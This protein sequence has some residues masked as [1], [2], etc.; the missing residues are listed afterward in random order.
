MAGRPAKRLSEHVWESSF[1]ARDHAHLLDDSELAEHPRL[2]RLQLAY[3]ETADPGLRRQLALAFERVS[4]NTEDAPTQVELEMF[5]GQPLEEASRPTRHELDAE[6]AEVVDRPP[7]PIEL[8]HDDAL[9]AHYW[10]AHRAAELFDAGRSG[11]EI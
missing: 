5:A 8:A 4:R 10:R 7:V 9:C 6:L 11:P 2:R 1:R 3:S